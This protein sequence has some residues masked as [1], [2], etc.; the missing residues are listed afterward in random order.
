VLAALI[1]VFRE[2]FEAGLIIGI[3]LAVT[4]GVD[5]RGS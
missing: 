5:H 3:V 1:I 4:R 2:V